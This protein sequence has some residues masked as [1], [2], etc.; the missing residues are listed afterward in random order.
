[1]AMFDLFGIKALKQRVLT[2]EK[3]V[4]GAEGEF[5]LIQHIYGTDKP[6][7]EGLWRKVEQL[8]KEVCKLPD[9]LKKRIV[10]MGDY[11]YAVPAECPDT[12]GIHLAHAY[13]PSH[14]PW[15]SASLSVSCPSFLLPTSEYE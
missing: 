8:E 6:G 7:Q 10:R 2:L 3:T 11:L 13:P 15:C 1:M 9:V 12:K 4:N 5:G 14:Y